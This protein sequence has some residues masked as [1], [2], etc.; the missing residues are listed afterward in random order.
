MKSSL[1]FS[2]V[3][4]A[5]NESASIEQ[6]L[7]AVLEQSYTQFEII[8]VD[9][10]STDTTV[11][12]VEAIAGV[13][14]RVRVVSCMRKG[15]LYARDAGYRAA[16]GDIIVQLDANAFPR[17]KDW[18][19]RAAHYFEYQD[20]VAIAGPYDFY[21]ARW[22]FRWGALASLRIIFPVLNWFVQKTHRG[23]FFI[24]GNAFLRKNV[25]DAIG[26]YPVTKTE[27]WFEDIIT[28]CAIAPHGW[29]A[30]KYDL[31]VA[32][33]AR[34]YIQHGYRC[35]QNEYN[36]G[37]LAVLLRRPFPHMSRASDL[38]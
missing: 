1:F 17:N 37:T 15:I 6:T 35:T 8:V 5:H 24:G 23:G 22:T 16:S 7:H 10:V 20:I 12:L 18:L 21:D 27:F 13:D 31:V 33:S 19:A 36:K 28:A 11:S 4:P 38:R 2:I 32:K 9:N 29:I 34:R 26:G 3:I 25:L 30:T 14:G